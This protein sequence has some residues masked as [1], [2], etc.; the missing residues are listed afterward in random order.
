LLNYAAFLSLS[1]KPHVIHV[2]ALKIIINLAGRLSV[3]FQNFKK[4]LQ[5]LINIK[6]GCDLRLLKIQREFFTAGYFAEQS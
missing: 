6:R 5:L 3:R 4:K 2:E 1:E